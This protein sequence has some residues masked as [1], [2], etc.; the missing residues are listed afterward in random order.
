[1]RRVNSTSL[2]VTDLDKRVDGAIYSVPWGRT[3]RKKKR[4]GSPEND[5]RKMGPEEGGLNGVD[6]NFARVPF[7]SDLTIPCV[8][9][10]TLDTWGSEDTHPVVIKFFI[11]AQKGANFAESFSWSVG[12][13]EKNRGEGFW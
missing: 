10:K 6:E 8:G 2:C 3:K 1:M 13:G 5:T 4:N 7:E 11:F 9:K 12:G